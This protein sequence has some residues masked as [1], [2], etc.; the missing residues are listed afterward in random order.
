MLK[1]ERQN[2]ILDRL[3]LHNKVLTT[4]LC[5][6]LNVSLDTV[7]R[8]LNGLKNE[9]KLIKV[10]GGA[11]SRNYQIP[12]QQKKVFKKEE[13]AVIAGKALKLIQADMDVFL[14][15]GTIMLELARLLPE[16]LPVRIYTISP[17]VALEISQRTKIKVVLIGGTVARE[18]YI[19]TGAQVAF[20][21]MEIKADICFLGTNGISVKE[22]IT[23]RD[24][25][26]AQVKKAMVNAAAKV[27][28]MAISERIGTNQKFQVCPVTSIDYVISDISPDHKNWKN[29]PATICFL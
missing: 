16:S 22:G 21:I 6:V 19:C 4:E 10:H 29:F 11:I 8:D 14:G 12:F 13:K 5:K 3:N 9:G 1:E 27:A 25:E 28:V 20:Q 2:I 26:A 17:L 18:S 7:R 15:G 24:Y 23:E